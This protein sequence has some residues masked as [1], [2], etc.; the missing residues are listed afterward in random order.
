ML[1]PTM[2]INREIYHKHRYTSALEKF[3]V[4]G[5]KYG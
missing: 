2:Y 5:V 3:K 1:G 4:T